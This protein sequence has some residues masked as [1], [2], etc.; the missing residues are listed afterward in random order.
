MLSPFIKLVARVAG[1]ADDS[2]LPFKCFM[3]NVVFTVY[4]HYFL[5]SKSNCGQK[6]DR[7]EISTTIVTHECLCW[8]VVGELQVVVPMAAGGSCVQ[9]DKLP[10][11][12]TETSV[13]INKIRTILFKL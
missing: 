13:H 5:F 7:E 10:A 4:F 2:V 1:M 12:V 11:F 6:T 3:E 8:L 9:W